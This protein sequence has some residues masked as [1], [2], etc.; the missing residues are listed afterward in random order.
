M[1]CKISFEVKKQVLGF[2]TEHVTQFLSIIAL[3]EKEVSEF[4]IPKLSQI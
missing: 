4:Y 2:V 1:T 3:L